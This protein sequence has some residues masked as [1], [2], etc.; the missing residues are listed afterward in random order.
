MIQMKGIDRAV[1]SFERYKKTKTEQLRQE[2][3][4]AALNIERKA[5]S[6][7]PVD[8][9]RL[10][11]S[12]HPVFTGGVDTATGVRVGKDGAAVVTNVVYAPKIEQDQPFLFPA[13]EAER[14]QYRQR[15]I[16]V[17]GTFRRR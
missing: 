1:K 6:T 16:E 3:N 5:K 14:P 10:K 13:W 7:V 11:S 17:L 8:T 15:I 2:T 12:I 9:G 4:R